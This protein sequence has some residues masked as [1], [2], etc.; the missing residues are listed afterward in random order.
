M[1]C[2]SA[3]GRLVATTV[4]GGLATLLATGASAQGIMFEREVRAA[5]MSDYV[6]RGVQLGEESFKLAGQL[7]FNGLHGGAILIQPLDGDAFSNE[8]RIYGG[9]SP[10]LEDHGSPLDIELGFT[11][12]AHPDSAPGFGDD[13]RFEPYAKLFI[14]AP[15]M[16]SIAGFYDAELET[17]TVEGR[18]TQWVE[19]GGLNGLEL[20]F[21]GGLVSPDAADDHAY[22]Q[23]SIDFVRNFLNGMEGYVGLRGSVSSEDRYFDSVTPVGPLYDQ[24]AK[25]WVAA[26]FTASF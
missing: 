16:P 10:H 3:L 1:P 11:W 6:F 8:A 13:S 23:G 21:D 5:V 26:G 2:P 14:D 15:L 17:Y 25:A 22:A 19:L 4:V 9:W 12:Y 20:G 24:R 7:R 18:L